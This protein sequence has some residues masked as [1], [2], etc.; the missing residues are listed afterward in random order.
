MQRVLIVLENIQISIFL[1]GNWTH[2]RPARLGTVYV[3]GIAVQIRY[4]VLWLTHFSFTM[5]HT[6]HSVDTK[7]PL[8][9]GI[10]IPSYWR[11]YKVFWKS[12]G[13]V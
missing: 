2:L 1:D 6:E 12:I 3:C 10:G 9:T 11:V 7:A 4:S 13:S 8:K 5:G